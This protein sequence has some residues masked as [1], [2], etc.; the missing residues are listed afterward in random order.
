MAVAARIRNALRLAALDEC[1]LARGLMPGQSLS[2]ARALIPELEVITG[3]SA[4]DRDLLTALATWCDRY[5]PLVALDG[6][7]GLFLDIT[8][9]AHLFGGERT[10]RED[11]A[12]RLTA[13]GFATRIAIADTPGAAWAISH[14]GEAR[15]VAPG[16]HGDA[17]SRLPLRALRIDDETADGLARMG[18]RTIACIAGLPRQPLTARF[19]AHLLARLDQAL[20]ASDEV[21][22]PLLPVPNLSSEKRFAEPETLQD[23][24][25]RAIHGLA[26]NLR[27]LMLRR[28]LGARALSLKLFRADGERS[29]L[30]VRT[31]APLRD[32][33]R[34]AALFNDR[35]AGLG[36]DLDAGF[37]FDIIRLDVT[38]SEPLPETQNDLIDRAPDSDGL[39]ALIDRLGARLGTDRI[40]RLPVKRSLRRA[41]VIDYQVTIVFGSFEKN[42]DGK[43]V[44]EARWAVLDNDKN[45]LLLR[46][47]E[48]SQNPTGADHAAQAAAQSRVLGLLGEEIAAAVLDLERAP[49]H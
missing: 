18:L 13:Q 44:L 27:T 38:Q 5:T 14:H 23:H 22:S 29:E 10:L 1:A 17:I 47:S 48:Y 7:G 41:L 21:M 36:S 46:R 32:P 9:C 43:V 16:R 4:A 39:T 45:E 31:A 20:G 2:D 24:I 33:A 49:G 8:G 30:T 25:H 6:T 12:R 28:G 40:I 11:L 37:G 26:G 34:I 19:G 42:P 35:I 15:I 3:D